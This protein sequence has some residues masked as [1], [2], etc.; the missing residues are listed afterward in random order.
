MHSVHDL[1]LRAVEEEL[2]N[3]AGAGPQDGHE[4]QVLALLLLEILGLRELR[5]LLERLAVRHQL[6]DD[7]LHCR[8]RGD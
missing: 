3:E 8:C 1:C 7:L 2:G 5:L 4:L 6:L